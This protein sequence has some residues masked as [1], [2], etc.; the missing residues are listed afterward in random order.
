MLGQNYFVFTIL[1]FFLST[2]S[3]ATTNGWTSFRHGP[4]NQGSSPISVRPF[5]Q[6]NQHRTPKT[7]AVGGLI[8]GTAI[9]DHQNNVYV[10]SS[11]KNFYKINSSGEIVWSY[12]IFDR[13]DSLI[14]SA[15]VLAPGNLVVIPGG[16]G[17][18]HAVN[19]DTGKRVW[20]FKAYHSSDAA[21]GQGAVVNSF[22]GN[23]QLGPNNM[24]YAGSDNGHM[25]ALDLSGKEKWNVKTNMMVWSSPAFSKRQNWMTF[26]SLDGNLY[27]VNRDTGELLDTYK[28]G[29]DIK[30][31]PLIDDGDNIYLGASDF[32]FY[33]FRV[34]NNKLVKRWVFKE[35][36]GEIYSSAALKNN[37]LV[38]GTLEGEVYAL[39][40]AGEKQW[41]YNTYA[42]MASSP[43]ITG[44]EVVIFGVK[45]GKL[46]ALDLTSGERIW[47]YR[48]SSGIRKSNLDASPSISGTGIIFNGS[49]AGIIYQ[50]PFEYCANN[51][52]DQRCEFGGK[53]DKPNF[54]IPVGENEATLRYLDS[55]GRYTVSPDEEIGLTQVLK[56]R[57]VVMREDL[58]QTNRGI[59]TLGVRVKSNP[60]A[61]FEVKVS[62]DGKYLN[63]LPKEALK[64][65]TSYQIVIS[66]FHYKQ[67]NWL[68]DRFNW[69]SFR[70]FFFSTSF[71][72]K[73]RKDSD[74]RV[75]AQG[76]WGIKSLYLEQPQ[77]L[78]TYI[79]AAM[80]GQ[81][82]IATPF[83]QNG[84]QFLLYVTPATPSDLG[85]VPLP[86]SSKT[87]VLKGR[88]KGED[89]F[90]DGSLKLSAMGGT[91]AF[92]RISL[93]G[94]L[95]AFESKKNLQFYSEAS[96]LG[97]KGNGTNYKFPLKLINK[98]CGPTLQ[99]RGMGEM[100][101]QH[102]TPA[103][104][105][106]LFLNDGLRAQLSVGKE[107]VKVELTRPVTR[108]SVLG[109]VLLDKS[110]ELLTYSA[111]E[112]KENERSK[113][114]AFKPRDLK[115]A[116]RIMLFMDHHLISGE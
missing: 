5:L 99:M 81:G 71:K 79:P 83:A 61:K 45:N 15:A 53:A 78:D 85:V 33:S 39:S 10:G 70:K 30:A 20:V 74:D 60:P 90:V 7:L 88:K 115:K 75:M 17:H 93:R 25:Y 18:L 43:L 31:S 64:A 21:H 24:L 23:V 87:F 65:D 106:D 35:A 94:Q 107:K 63:L 13:A 48:T 44:D 97:L 73:S 32:Y 112:V 28:I 80:D 69:L 27:L 12:K 54:G 110:N 84:E 66:G 100:G 59:N 11:N 95:P 76:V 51:R 50:V 105:P 26:G 49:Y 16:D 114:L 1:I 38:F 77:A 3:Y 109:V 29:K 34:E 91:I 116:V 72:T 40:T 104:S 47:S 103:T 89:L 14:D 96:C 52:G 102:F 19:R 92:K 36:H 6:E 111:V 58:W 37:T 41:A 113:E 56:F 57:L 4:Q 68:A 8:W 67:R 2:S 101:L 22:E 9:I 82:F 42:P 108:K 98:V 55:L 86:E 62:S 46:F